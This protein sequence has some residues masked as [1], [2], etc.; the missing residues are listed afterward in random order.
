MESS[1]NVM[2]SIALSVIKTKESENLLNN[3]LDKI[4]ERAQNGKFWL[5][6]DQYNEYVT[7]SLRNRGFEVV[8]HEKYIQIYWRV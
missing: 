3:I 4:L 5:K 2:R 1:A 7:E 6:S 8:V